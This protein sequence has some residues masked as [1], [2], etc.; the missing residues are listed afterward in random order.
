MIT[1]IFRGIILSLAIFGCVYGYFLYAGNTG[2]LRWWI[3]GNS[4]STAIFFVSAVLIYTFQGGN[5]FQRFGMFI[6]V[7]IDL[8]LLGDM[9]FRNN[10]GMNNQQF[11]ILFG[12]VLLALAVTYIWHRI[13]FVIMGIIWIG[14]VFVLLTG[15]LPMYET[16]PSIDD[17][18]STQKTR[19]LNEWTI[20]EGMLTI[21]NALGSKDIPV[22]Q[23]QQIDLD[24]SQKTQISYATK[25]LIDSGKI[26]IDIGNGSFININP[27][28]ALTLEQSW[29][30]VLME[31][32]QGDVGYYT[33]P[34][35]SGAF[36]V[37]GKYVGRNI[38]DI[39][40]TV[41]AT[42]VNQFEQKKQE[43]FISQIWGNM[44]LNPTINRIIRTFITTLHTI[45]PKTYENNR[46]NYHKIQEYLGNKSEETMTSGYTGTS[47]KDM[48]DD[49]MVQMRKWAE[50]TKFINT[51]INK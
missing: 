19:I 2:D 47:I 9:F 18:I 16:I 25:S 23:F 29:A 10:I 21:K 50:E 36:Q 28:S 32:I 39:Q 34:V 6:I 35:L 3:Q 4:I 17:F 40:N 5:R 51:L 41:W 11:L 22:N 20:E 44:M 1:R 26:F 45:S 7:L 12:L 38:K 46:I 49:I 14:I 37:M 31:I 30:S 8:Y 42:L 27:Q 33:P 13:R 15:V 24:L 43:Y 48:I